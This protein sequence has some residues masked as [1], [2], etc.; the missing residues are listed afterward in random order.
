[1]P[2]QTATG[3]ELIAQL[4]QLPKKDR[5]MVQGRVREAARAEYNRRE[6]IKP[7]AVAA[8]L[9]RT[10]TPAELADSWHLVRKAYDSYPTAHRDLARLHPAPY[11]EYAVID[12]DNDSPTRGLPLVLSKMHVEIVQTLMQHRLVVMMSSREHGSTTVTMGYL[13]W[14]LGKNHDM[15]IKVV[16]EGLK[17]AKKRVKKFRD[18]LD[19]ENAKAQERSL[20]DV[21][22]KIRDV[23]P[24]MRRNRTT[25]RWETTAFDVQ[26]TIASE[27]PSV[28][29]G[30]VLG[31]GTGGRT[32]L[33]F[34]DDPVG[35]RNAITN[36][37]YKPRVRTAFFSDWFGTGASRQH[38]VAGNFW[39]GDDLVQ[40]LR[41]R[42]SKTGEEQDLPSGGTIVVGEQWV[43]LAH[44]IDETTNRSCWPERWPREK[45]AKVRSGMPPVDFARGWFCRE[46]TKEETE[47]KESDFKFVKCPARESF[48]MVFAALDTSKS[49]TEK[50]TYNGMVHVGLQEFDPTP[51]NP[52][53]VRIVVMRANRGH[54]KEL[55]ALVRW[56][57]REYTITDPDVL[58][59][60]NADRGPDVA[61]MVEDELGI[62]MD[63]ITQRE[64]KRERLNRHIPLHR[65]GIV[66]YDE[67]L[68]PELI[69]ERGDETE[70]NLIA[71]ILGQIG[72][73]DCAD[74]FEICLRMIRERVLL[75]LSDEADEDADLYH[76]TGND[77]GDIGNIGVDGATAV[78]QDKSHARGAQSDDW[79]DG[80]GN[81]PSP[82]TQPEAVARAQ[83]SR[84]RP[85]RGTRRGGGFS[86]MGR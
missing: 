1:M 26:G 7:Y 61:D 81:E 24:T 3:D 47:Y 49:R 4:Y 35:M 86:S 21:Y 51:A 54:Y 14:K 32:D 57:V 34:Y 79:W 39:A 37:S 31:G 12:T 48:D 19:D 45:V 9:L 82:P 5:E 56:V 77:H 16:G 38:I 11:L 43:S 33:V 84:G 67:S 36:P 59:V 28:E 10:A 70:A 22:A 30:G 17:A 44:V 80:A 85:Q 2:D 58:A 6:R 62:V 71:E 60:E 76:E 40:E 27:E 42:A 73:M 41:Y 83:R 50:A 65:K 55:N 20:R 78:Q 13:E 25:G 15:R 68:N 23:F 29:G 66:V 18:R 52:W 75:D 63:L 46:P 64:A 74:P 69:R 8:D 72:T 53:G